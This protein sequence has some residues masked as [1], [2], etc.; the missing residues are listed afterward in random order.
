MGS[1]VI[2]TFYFEFLFTQEAYQQLSITID[3]PKKLMEIGTSRDLGVCKGIRK[4]DGRHCTM[5]INK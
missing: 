2:Y 4:K 3:N 5:Y 1:D